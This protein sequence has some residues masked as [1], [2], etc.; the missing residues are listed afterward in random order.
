MRGRPGFKAVLAVDLPVMDMDR[1]TEGFPTA[2][3]AD[4][5]TPELGGVQ[6]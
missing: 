1:D 5:P 6:L 4:T 2:V 3:A